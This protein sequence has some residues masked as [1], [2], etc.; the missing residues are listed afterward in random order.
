[1]NNRFIST[2]LIIVFCIS[3]T[4]CTKEEKNIQSK[5]EQTNKIV[6]ERNNINHLKPK[7]NEILNSISKENNNVGILASIDIKDKYFW[8]GASGISEFDRGLQANSNMK[9]IIASN[10]KVF[11]AAIALKLVEEGKISLNDSISK[12]IG[13]YKNL[14]GHITIK[15]LLNHTS[16]IFDYAKH[17]E[18]VF[19]KGF[20]PELKP[21]EMK[22]QDI[23]TNYLDEPYFEPGKGWH[24]SSTNYVLLSVII[25]KITGY[26]MKELIEKFLLVPY[27][28]SDTYV[29]SVFLIQNN[30]NILHGFYDIDNDGKREDWSKE[31][32]A[33]H[34]SPFVYCQMIST[35]R[36]LAKW[37]YKYCTGEVLSKEMT[38]EMTRFI[39][40]VIGESWAQGYGL[41]IAYGH[42]GSHE[43][44]GH[45]G[46][47][48]GYMS[49]MGYMPAY[50]FSFSIAINTNNESVILSA[51][52]Q[53]VMEVI[54]HLNQKLQE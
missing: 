53:L 22:P 51:A 15:Q 44:W 19:Q 17:P 54:K 25:E 24:Y 3:I 11:I 13:E 2:L 16:G 50:D 30:N 4:N 35:T 18:S 14:S 7:L 1:M 42:I 36:D 45:A 39:K 27:K 48:F 23:L 21:L 41:G 29:S 34:I 31:E 43:W 5:P 52:A 10:N 46:N 6:I 28:L 49:A 8:D 37:T 20:D 38:Y 33:Q 9:F 26:K 40:P 32:L 47:T 12:Y